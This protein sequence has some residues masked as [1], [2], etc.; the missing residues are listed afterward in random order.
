MIGRAKR[1]LQTWGAVAADFQQSIGELGNMFVFFLHPF[2]PF[3][4]GFGDRFGQALSGESGQ[5]LGEF[6]GIFV[7]NVK[8]H[9]VCILPC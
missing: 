7:F 3:A 9:M 6:V 1:F 5:A 4:D 2:K 8:A